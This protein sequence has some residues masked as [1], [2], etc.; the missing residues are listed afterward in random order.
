MLVREIQEF[1]LGQTSRTICGS[2]KKINVLPRI[3]RSFQNVSDS[4]SRIVYSQ[5]S[6]TIY[7]PYDLINDAIKF[8]KVVELIEYAPI[9]YQ[10]TFFTSTQQAFSFL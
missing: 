3:Y 8:L 1:Y 7:I 4:F 10:R 2:G 9:V 5:C 6:D